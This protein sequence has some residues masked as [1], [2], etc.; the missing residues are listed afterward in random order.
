MHLQPTV[1]MRL[2]ENPL[3]QSLSATRGADWKH[4]WFT[5]AVW[6]PQKGAWVAVVMA[7]FVNGTAPVVRASAADLRETRGTFFG[8]LVDA[9]TGAA[10]IAQ[11]ARLAIETE[12]GIPDDALM[13]VPISQKP[14]VPLSSW[15]KVGYGGE[16]SVPLFFRD[17][18]VGQPPATEPGKAQARPPA[19]NRLLCACDVFLEQ[20]RTALSATVELTPTAA[21]SSLV[22]QTLA[23][24]EK[25]NTARV[26]LQSGEFSAFEQSQLNFRGAGSLVAD[27]QEQTTDRIKVST[28]WMVS[29]PDVPVES[30]P[31]AT[32]QP[33]AQHNLFWNLNWAQPLLRGAVVVN[34]IFSPLLGVL[35]VLGTGAGFFWASATVAGI[36]DATQ[37]AYNILRAMSLEGTFWT[38]TGGGT[39]SAW[40]ETAVPE[41]KPGID[42]GANAAA[43][44]AAARQTKLNRRLDPP[45]PFEG[46]KFNRSLLEG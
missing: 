36:A 6:L 42:K 38:A 26:R 11:L 3:G 37:S 18:G 8:Q 44:A 22:S 14:P 9:R 25:P 19:G 39:T 29:P 7:G 40:P 4:P 1:N 43:Q 16:G 34:D 5:E 41:V 2:S 12:D 10:E 35:S 17:R 21:G 32:W 45:F 46:L 20:P 27:Y 23:M 33:F 31:D 24:E 28:V 30:Q 13:D 15:R